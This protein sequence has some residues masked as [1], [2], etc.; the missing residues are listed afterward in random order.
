MTDVIRRFLEYKYQ[1]AA[2]EKTSDE[3]LNSLS[4]SSINKNDYNQ[5]KNLFSLANMIKF[6]KSM[7]VAEE[8]IQAMTIAKGLINKE[9]RKLK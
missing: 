9:I 4:L 8:N 6:A 5:L 3:I 2:L 7:P 1:I